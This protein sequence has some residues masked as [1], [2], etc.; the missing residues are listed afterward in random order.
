MYIVNDDQWAKEMDGNLKRLRPLVIDLSHVLICQYFNCPPLADQPQ[1]QPAAE[2]GDGAAPPAPAPAAPAQPVIPAF[3]DFIF[4]AVQRTRT[5][6]NAM[7]TGLL[8]VQRLRD[9][10]PNCVGTA[11]TPHRVMLAG[12]M[13]ACKVLYDDT[14][15]NRTWVHVSQGLFTLAEIN[16]MEWEFL[17]YL[18]FDLVI[19]RAMWHAHLARLDGQI[20]TLI[21][22]YPASGAGNPGPQPS[23]Q[24]ELNQ[25]FRNEDTYVPPRPDQVDETGRVTLAHPA[26]QQQQLPQTAQPATGLES[27]GAVAAEEDSAHHDAARSLQRRPS[28]S[29]ARHAAALADANQRRSAPVLAVPPSQPAEPARQTRSASPPSSD[30][31]AHAPAPAPAP[32]T[33][34]R[35][36]VASQYYQPPPPPAPQYQQQHAYAQLQ[37]SASTGAAYSASA[38]PAAGA[39]VY[40]GQQHAHPAT[41]V[42]AAAAA[43]TANY[44]AS[45][46]SGPP[47]YPYGYAASAATGPVPSSSVGGPLP[48]RDQRWYGYPGSAPAAVA[49]ASSASS[50]HPMY[51]PSLRQQQQQQQAAAAGHHH[52]VQNSMHLPPPPPP[53]MAYQSMP[54]PPQQPGAPQQQYQ[55]APGARYPY[56]SSMPEPHH[57]HTHAHPHAAG[58]E[59]ANRKRPLSPASHARQCSSNGTGTGPAYSADAYASHTAS[60]ARARTGAHTQQT[61]FPS[62]PADVAARSASVSVRRAASGASLRPPPPPLSKRGDS[63]T[64]LVSMP[65][66]PVPAAVVGRDRGDRG[67]EAG[68]GV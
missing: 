31:S 36:P 25:S 56:S 8:L 40:H 6:L 37:R 45:R 28:R 29:A 16:R 5:P 52:A 26:P 43:S 13:L 24:A 49:P 64:D 19:P 48:P 33:H 61:G 21:N 65:S 27:A 54:P 66:Q 23:L 11:V 42:A 15:S 47:A 57:A 20:T 60:L 41:N 2:D 38:P 59:S 9:R 1:Q 68:Y 12:I 62:M 50:K 7:V 35:A 18:H 4:N 67:G 3:R 22:S 51:H 14:Y 58:A 46:S 32:A 30:S 55:Q 44:Y 34:P 63:G 10:N 17:E 53:P 39:P